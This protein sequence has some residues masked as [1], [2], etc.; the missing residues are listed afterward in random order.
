MARRTNKQSPLE[1]LSFN[2]PKLDDVEQPEPDPQPTQ[3]DTVPEQPIEKT[4]VKTRSSNVTLPINVWDWIDLKH[5][6]ARSKGG[7]PIRKSA[8]FRAVF[9]VAMSV[10]VDLSGVQSEE[11][12]VERLKNAIVQIIE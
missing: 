9:E 8:I 12:I 2:A 4:V 1:E 3:Q 10:D 7:K 11:E 6:E 5:I